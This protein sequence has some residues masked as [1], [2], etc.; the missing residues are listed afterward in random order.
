MDA[1][2]FVLRFSNL[3]ARRYKLDIR[4]LDVPSCAILRISQAFLASIHVFINLNMFLSTP[5]KITFKDLKFPRAL[6][7]STLYHPTSG[8]KII[9][10]ILRGSHRVF[11][12][13]YYSLPC[14]VVHGFKE[15][16]H[17]SFPIIIVGVIQDKW[18]TDLSSFL[19]IVHLNRIYFP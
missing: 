2:S 17:F 14:F 9:F 8:F 11:P 4:T 13:F 1:S 12:T 3:V 10:F 6:S 19:S 5:L 18:S 16:N 15:S 7:S